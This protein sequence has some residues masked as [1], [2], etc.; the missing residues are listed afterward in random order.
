MDDLSRR[1]FIATSVGALALLH[2]PLGALACG[3]SVAAGR[4][5]RLNVA[6]AARRNLRAY[7]ENES[8]L[9]LAGLVSRTTVEGKLGSYAADALFLFPWTK[10]HAPGS[11]PTAYLPVGAEE[12]A[13]TTPFTPAGVALDEQFC[14]YVLQAPPENFIGF[15]VDT[16]VAAY[17]AHHPWFA[18]VELPGGK[19][20]GIR[21][22]SGNL[23]PPWFAGSTWAPPDTRDGAQVRNLVINGLREA[24][25]AVA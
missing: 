5:S 17:L 15:V 16:P 11:L 10:S 22:T 18:N 9:G 8:A 24:A 7:L 6:Y 1:S 23:N 3:Q 13:T 19:R 25:S 4:P 20:V 21:W 14:R 2:H 12:I